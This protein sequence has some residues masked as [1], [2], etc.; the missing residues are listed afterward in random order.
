VAPRLPAPPLQARLLAVRPRHRPASLQFR[1]PL[2]VVGDLL[3]RRVVPPGRIPVLQGPRRPTVAGIGLQYPFPGRLGRLLEPLFGQVAGPLLDRP[4]VSQPRL[5]GHLPAGALLVE[6]RSA[7]QLQQLP[8]LFRVAVALPEAIG[9]A[10]HV[11]QTRLVPLPGLAQVFQ[12]PRPALVAGQRPERLDLVGPQ[13]V[14]GRKLRVSVHQLAGGRPEVARLAVVVGRQRR[15]IHGRRR[16]LV[17]PILGDV[18]RLEGRG[19]D[20]IAGQGHSAPVGRVSVRRRRREPD[21]AAAE[22]P[23]PVAEETQIE[24]V[25]VARVDRQFDQHAVGPRLEPHP[26]HPLAGPVVVGGPLEDVS[27]VDADLARGRE[28]SVQP[29]A[30]LTAPVF[31]R[32]LDGRERLQIIDSPPRDVRRQRQSAAQIGTPLLAVDRPVFGEPRRQKLPL[33]PVGALDR[34]RPVEIPLGPRRQPGRAHP[35][36]REPEPVGPERFRRLRCLPA[37]VGRRLPDQ[38]QIHPCQRLECV[39]AGPRQQFA[40]AF[41]VVD[42]AVAQIVQTSRREPV[43]R[44]RRLDPEHLGEQLEGPL[45]VP[46]PVA[47]LGLGE[48]PLDPQISALLP[49]GLVAGLTRSRLGGLG[50]RRGGAA[51]PPGV[52]F[53]GVELAVEPPLHRPGRPGV[54]RNLVASPLVGPGRTAGDPQ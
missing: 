20:R 50:S 23:G 36:S 45:G 43:E 46:G 53:F 15:Q 16:R 17:E 41:A 7:G 11:G 25:P 5:L 29:V 38:R 21:A 37:P 51:V 47:D 52:E 27:P 42:D 12:R 9:D 4:D 30:A 49:V 14:G 44:V 35:R 39:V 2:P 32:R 40:D 24:P 48:G 10:Q 8:G 26:P 33:D 31:L 28:V 1:T 34:K 19:P 13:P 54:G 18:S 22:R 6:G 3:E